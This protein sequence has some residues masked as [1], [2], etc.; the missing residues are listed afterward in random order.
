MRNWAVLGGD[1]IGSPGKSSSQEHE[2]A[3]GT[4]DATS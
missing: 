2:D 4:R 1:L 3:V